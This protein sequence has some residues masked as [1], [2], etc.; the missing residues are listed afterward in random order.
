[1]N[2]LEQ[3][4]QDFWANQT[5]P[6]QR[7]E[8]LRQLEA[9]GMEW[10][11]FLHQYY[12]KVMSGEESSPLSDQQK[13]KVWGRLWDTH[14]K[15]TSTQAPIIELDNNK[16][17]SSSTLPEQA[18]RDDAR[19]AAKLT[20][21]LPWTAAAA[22]ACII[23]I[24][25]LT[26][27]NNKPEK[28]TLQI[29]AQK[30]QQP[31]TQN[32]IKAANPGPTEKHLLLPDSSKAILAPGSVLEYVEN[33]ETT[34]R[35]IHLEGRALF[36][37]AKDNKRPF[38]VTARGFATTALGTQFIVDATRS[39]VSIRLLKGKVMVNATAK[40]GMNI[41]KL[42]LTPGQEL[43][44]NTITKRFERTGQNNKTA[45]NN[46]ANNTANAAALNFEKTNL[47]LVFKR[48]SEHYKIPITYGKA[49]INGLSF[50]GDFNPTDDLE[51]ALKVICNMNQLTF[52]KEKGSIV[53]SKQ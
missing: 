42:I 36:D 14:L 20:R 22:A 24:L 1:M 39:V 32:I 19:G 37:V 35:N 41:E 5:T 13:N 45:T 16:G 53:I 52:T 26:I 8:I 6:E 28:Q 38:T 50:T 2:N 33:F 43:K 44:I 3:Q 31:P 11:E 15:N 7:R 17:K 30:Q 46:A 21:W 49:D 48:L 18:P 4:I 29:T 47:A 10:Q 34:A 12:N 25:T 23:A 40:A 9:S 27:N 51:L